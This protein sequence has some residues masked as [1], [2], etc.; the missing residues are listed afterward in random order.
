MGHTNNLLPTVFKSIYR[1]LLHFVMQS[2]SASH[3]QCYSVRC[4]NCTKLVSQFWRTKSID[5]EWTTI[6]VKYII[7]CYFMSRY[8]PLFVH[9]DFSICRASPLVQT[10]N[11][12]NS[13]KYKFLYNLWIPSTRKILVWHIGR[14][15]NSWL[16]REIFPKGNS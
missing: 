12:R 10:S 7:L 4:I 15:W 6:S 5:S 8:S 3:R 14:T 1:S 2:H 9:R 11:C 16:N 13:T